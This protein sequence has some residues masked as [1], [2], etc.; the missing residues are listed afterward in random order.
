MRIKNATELKTTKV[1]LEESFMKIHERKSTARNKNLSEVYKILDKYGR[2]DE[3]VDKVF[4]RAPLIEQR[5]M[6]KLLKEGRVDKDAAE[7]A[8]LRIEKRFPNVNV[9]I[10]GVDRDV[11][12][13]PEQGYLDFNTVNEIV[14]Y[15]GDLNIKGKKFAVEMYTQD[16]DNPDEVVGLG[17]CNL[18]RGELLKAE[19]YCVADIVDKNE[20]YG[21]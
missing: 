1:N 12:L 4:R 18:S 10:D 8:K 9:C 15:V 17:Q 7:I 16:K 2:V 19:W 21:K 5:K 6:V 20:Y 11:L 3:D 13:I 14:N